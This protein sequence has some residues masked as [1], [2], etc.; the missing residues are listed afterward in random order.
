MNTTAHQPQLFTQ[1][2]TGEGKGRI[3][4]EP[5]YFDISLFYYYSFIFKYCTIMSILQA[6]ELGS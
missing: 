6:E 1:D 3:Y 2:D 5:L 4:F